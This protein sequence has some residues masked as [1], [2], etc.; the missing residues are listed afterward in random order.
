MLSS[1]FYDGLLTV[2]CFCPAVPVFLQQIVSEKNYPR[3]F[4]FPKALSC[5]LRFL[6]WRN[7]FATVFFIQKRLRLNLVAL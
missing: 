2:G 6:A 5:S 1:G 3:D 4:E 7:I